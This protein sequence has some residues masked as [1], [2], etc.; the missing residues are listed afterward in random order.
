MGTGSLPKSEEETRV[1]RPERDGKGKRASRKLAEERELRRA[2]RSPGPPTMRDSVL[3]TI[4]H[5]DRKRHAS[6][7]GPESPVC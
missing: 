1:P 2:A 6:D 3:V 4:S 7:G 5:S